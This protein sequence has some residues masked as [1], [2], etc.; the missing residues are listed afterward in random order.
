MPDSKN[1][2]VLFACENRLVKGGSAGRGAPG[3]GGLPPLSDVVLPA[4]GSTFVDN[5]VDPSEVEVCP[6]CKNC[7]PTVRAVPFT[8]VKVRT[9]GT[10]W[11]GLQAAFD[12]RDWTFC[13]NEQYDLYSLATDVGAYDVGACD[14]DTDFSVVIVDLQR[15]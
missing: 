14:L 7:A 13:Q 10:G 6:H 5:E 8:V 2:V 3:R 4:E 15:N 1:I 9:V 11:T 12:D